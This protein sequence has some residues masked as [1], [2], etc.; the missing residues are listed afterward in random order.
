MI[1]LITGQ[2]GAGK[3]LYGLNYVR[4]WAEKEQRP[5]YYNGINDLKLP[6]IEF[7]PGEDWHTCPDGSIIVI[8][9]CQRVFRPRGTGGQVPPHVVLLETHRHRGIDIVLVT[10]H[11]M[12][13]DTNVRRLCGRHFHVVRAFGAKKATVHE[14]AEV[15]EQCDKQRTGSIRHDF[16]YP[17]S[18]FQWYKSAEIHTHKARIP[19]RVFM[20][21][22]IPLLLGLVGWYM[23]NWYEGRSKESSTNPLSLGATKQATS[24]SVLTVGGRS[25][26]AASDPMQWFYDRVP[27]VSTMPHTA[28]MYDNVT[29]AVEAPIPAACVSTG[30]KC[31][32]WSQ[33]ATLMELDEKACR[34]I[35]KTGYFVAWKREK[36]EK[37]AEKRAESTTTTVSEPSPLPIDLSG[38]GSI[39][40]PI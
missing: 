9:E 36:R 14:W 6:W 8:D 16:F 3:T 7:T 23:V 28:P 19:P 35:V 24:A 31:Q 18:S 26:N 2:P 5:V 34:G 32:C 21:L 33:Q 30:S 38:R 25:Q 29:Q 15:R 22:I 10:Q 12:L 40:N 37:P 27:R 11:P 20:L 4:E 13:A 1:T 39:P 17:K